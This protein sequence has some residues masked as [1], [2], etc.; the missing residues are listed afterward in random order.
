MCTHLFSWQ[1]S[2]KCW[3][4][5]GTVLG[6]GDHLVTSL[7]KTLSL[8]SIPLMEVNG[9]GQKG[10]VVLKKS[11]GRK[12]YVTLKGQTGIVWIESREQG[13]GGCTEAG[14]V[15][16]GPLGFRMPIMQS[17]EH[18]CVDGSIPKLNTLI[19]CHWCTMACRAWG[20]T[21]FC[22]TSSD[23][24]GLALPRACVTDGGSLSK[25][26]D[27]RWTHGR[28]MFHRLILCFCHVPLKDPFAWLDNATY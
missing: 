21:D 12:K 24:R 15:D 18:A 4:V 23:G 14:L 2:V 25:A 27:T 5:P 1:I 8:G 16:R 28:A 7:A 6:C 19:V 20:N 11:C 3:H 9:W 26:V 22:Q 10:R 17:L 13:E